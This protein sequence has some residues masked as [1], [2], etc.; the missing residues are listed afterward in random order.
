MLLSV[1]NS[2][3]KLW[4]DILSV[5]C[6]YKQEVKYKLMH[7]LRFLTTHNQYVVEVSSAMQVQ[8]KS[9]NGLLQRHTTCY[10][11][12]LFICLIGRI[13]AWHALPA[14]NF[15]QGKLKGHEEMGAGGVI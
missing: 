9:T 12:P 13:D 11:A 7:T 5:H 4:Q 3:M 10:K 6:L 15:Q 1:L 2:V 14:G 8:N